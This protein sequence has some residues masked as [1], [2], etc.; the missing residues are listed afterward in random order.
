MVKIYPLSRNGKPIF[1]ENKDYNLI[2]KWGNQKIKIFID[3]INDIMKNYFVD[4]KVWYP[5]GAG[6]TDPLKGGLG[7]YLNKN[8]PQLNPRHASVLAAIMV[9]EG[10]IENKDLRSILVRKLKISQSIKN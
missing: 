5:L 10:L 1:Y 3:I 4:F 2:I 8:Y 9:H 6:M 7:E